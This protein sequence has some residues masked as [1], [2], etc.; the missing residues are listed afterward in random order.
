MSDQSSTTTQPFASVTE[1]E[2]FWGKDLDSTEQARATILL[3]YAS[4]YLRQIA[5]NNGVDIDEKISAET[6]DIFAN[7]VKMVI[8][9]VVKR[10]M[11][12]PADAPAAD[13]WSQVATPYSES[14]SNFTNPGGDLFF[15]T[16]ELQL[17]GF[18]RISGKSQIGIIRGIR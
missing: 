5:N 16:N 6:S 7:A 4:D 1:L 17:L 15:K 10:A 14:I 8:L 13:S 12:T 9:S 11:T 2:A 18:S 3:Q